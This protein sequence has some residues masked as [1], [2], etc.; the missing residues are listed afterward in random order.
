MDLK[1]AGGAAVVSIYV[2]QDEDHWRNTVEHV[3]VA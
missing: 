2:G 3:R 1:E